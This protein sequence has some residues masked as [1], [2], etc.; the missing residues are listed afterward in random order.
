MTKSK[1]I[2]LATSWRFSLYLM[3]QLPAAWFM[4]LRVSS[5]NPQRASVSLPYSWFSKNPFRSTYFAAQ[6]AAAELSTGILV[7]YHLQEQPP[8]SMLVKNVEGAFTKKASEKLTFIC[9]MG[10]EIE[11]AVLA[12]LTEPDGAEIR[13][14]SVGHLPDGTVAST[15]WFTWGLKRKAA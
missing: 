8:V 9:E 13:V 7:L 15:F 14:R 6:T 2:G 5:L 4:G 11:G 3:T 12:A 10:E 1:L